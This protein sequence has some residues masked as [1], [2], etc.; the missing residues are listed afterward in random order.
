VMI[1]GIVN[2]GGEKVFAL[3]FLQAR[4]P[5]FVRRPF[6]AKYDSSATWFDQ[7]VPAFGEKRF[8]FE[9]DSSHRE[10]RDMSQIRITPHVDLPRKVWAGAENSLEQP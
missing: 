10:I 6:Y 9:E 8:F 7:L 1:D 5:S 3:Q 2:I 4:N